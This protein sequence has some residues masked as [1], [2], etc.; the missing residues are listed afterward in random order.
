VLIP[1]QGI[2]GAA[3]ATLVSYTIATSILFVLFLKESKMPWHEALIVRPADLALW[4][5]M[6]GHAWEGVR[7]RIPARA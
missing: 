1:R 6:A 4:K 5:Q 3:L 7:R 2:V